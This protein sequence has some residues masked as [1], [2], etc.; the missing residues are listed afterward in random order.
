[1]YVCIG[2]LDGLDDCMGW[3]TVCIAFW[4]VL[5]YKELYNSSFI[6]DVV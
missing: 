2:W 4:G 6:I 3:M 5:H 1:M